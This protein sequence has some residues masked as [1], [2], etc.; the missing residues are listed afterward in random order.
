MH[1]LIKLLL[2]ETD[3]F[4]VVGWGVGGVNMAFAFSMQTNSSLWPN[5]CLYLDLILN[6]NMRLVLI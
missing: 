6:T 3:Q 4:W 5:E 1:L 2:F